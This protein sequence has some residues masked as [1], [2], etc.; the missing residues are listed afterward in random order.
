MKRVVK[1]TIRA[2]SDGMVLMDMLVQRFTYHDRSGWQR[3]V[4]DGR[5]LING[6]AA[7]AGT[8]LR[9]GDVLE[10]RVPPLAEPSVPLSAATVYEDSDVLAVDKP[11]GLPTHPS[12]RFFNHTLWA[13]L[14]AARPCE[15][16]EF[17]NR[18]DRETSGLVLLGRHAAATRGLRRQMERRD[19]VKE[20]LVLVEGS[21][22]PACHAEG[23]L[24]RDSGSAVRKKRGYSIARPG[25]DS[26]EVC[27]CITELQCVGFSAGVSLV[28][29]RPLTG[30]LHQI[31]ATLLGLGFP[32]V[33]D[34]LYGVDE[35]IFLRFAASGDLS[36]EDVARL[37]LARQALHAWRLCLRHPATGVP[38]T[39]EAPVPADLVQLCSR[40]GMDVADL[41]RTTA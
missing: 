7:A 20:Y 1:T 22:P 15:A 35:S 36:S 16:F 26:S 28:L 9:T 10:F 13:V 6:V 30:R 14:K 4:S 40:L 18:L 37:R 32:V 39:L 11:A 33:G 25:S 23:W 2:N 21:F 24:S 34:K 8:I 19:I 41:S 12:G 5:L 31:R 17:V 29:A 3:L 27:A 38:L